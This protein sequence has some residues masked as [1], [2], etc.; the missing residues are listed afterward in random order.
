MPSVCLR[1]HVKTL[2]LLTAALVFFAGLALFPVS[3][4]ADTAPDSHVFEASALEAFAAESKADGDTTSDG[5]FTL[6]WSAKSK[7]DGSSKTWED[8]YASGQRVNFGGK[9]TVK[10]NALRF[11]TDGPATVKVWWV[12]SGED[13][14]QMGILNADGEVVV[15]TSGEY[16]KNS[17]YYSELILDAAGTWYRG[18]IGGNNYIFKVEVTQGAAEKPAR[19][20][21]DSVSA[22][23]VLSVGLAEGDP[24]TV[25]VL[26]Q[27]DV[28]YAGAWLRAEHVN[29]RDAGL[30]NHLLGAVV[31]HA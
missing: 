9:A 12:Q 22:P 29:R 24:K 26:V 2:L 15:Q 16:E 31:E 17:P 27:A 6:L 30:P 20:A 7:V 14:R 18:G 19:S 11:E 23:A 28:S 1:N 4:R 10:K 13:H 3:G 21:W 5:F 25:E 8:G